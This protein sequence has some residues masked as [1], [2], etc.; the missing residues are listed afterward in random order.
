MTYVKTPKAKA[1]K[2]PAKNNLEEITK[3]IA[4]T[5][6]GETTNKK[7]NHHTFWSISVAFLILTWELVSLFDFI[8]LT[9]NDWIVSIIEILI[10]KF[11]RIN[12]LL[13]EASI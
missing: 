13:C 7:Q 8:A 10:Y 4:P 1:T 12:I 11:N 2:V 5:A 6:K 3:L 9:K